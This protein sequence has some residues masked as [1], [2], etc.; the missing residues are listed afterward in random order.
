MSRDHENRLTG[1]LAKERDVQ[2]NAPVPEKFIEQLNVSSSGKEGM[3]TF[4][5][6]QKKITYTVLS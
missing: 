5:N 1:L 2:L 4:N 3:N 6:K